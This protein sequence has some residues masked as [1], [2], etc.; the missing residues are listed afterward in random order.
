M[1]S[2]QQWWSKDNV[3]ERIAKKKN[4][5][6]PQDNQSLNAILILMQYAKLV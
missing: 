6:D 5:F 3:G 2:L 1:D 4:A